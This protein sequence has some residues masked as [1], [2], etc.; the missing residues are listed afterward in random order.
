M[1]MVI[2]ANAKSGLGD[3][4]GSAF[5]GAGEGAQS[6]VGGTAEGAGAGVGGGA[7]VLVK[8]TPAYGHSLT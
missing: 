7:A 6:G 8:L 4:V 5:K 1:V 3:Q 2:T